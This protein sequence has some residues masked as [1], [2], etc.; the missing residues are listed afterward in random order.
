[1]EIFR[2]DCDWAA[3]HQMNSCA[4]EYCCGVLKICS[5]GAS[6]WGEFA[7]AYPQQKF[8]MIH[9]ACVFTHLKGL[10]IAGA[11]RYVQCGPEGWDDI[12]QKAA[13]AALSDLARQLLHPADQPQA[14]AYP[15]TRSYLI[16]HSQAYFSC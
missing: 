8:D 15:L 12:R 14:A 11:I 3:G 6:G 2:F 1:M 16:A 13:L 5:S 7:F 9:W 10:S 4:G